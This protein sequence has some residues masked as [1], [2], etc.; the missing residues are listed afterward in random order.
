M[1]KKGVRVEMS[2]RDVEPV[3]GFISE[4]RSICDGLEPGPV[5]ALINGAL[6]R[7]EFGFAPPPLVDG[8]ETKEARGWKIPKPSNSVRVEREEWP[9]VCIIIPVFNSP[10]LLKRCLSSLL[11]TDYPG[12]VYISCVDNASTDPET[13]HIL[14]Q[15]DYPPLRFESPVGFASAVNAGIKACGGFS[16]YVLFN[17]DCQVIEEDWLTALIDWMEQR[18]QC[19][20]AGAKLLYPDGTLQH[21][22]MEIPKGS[23]G[24]HRY[25][26][27]SADLEEANYFEK[28]QSVTGAVYCIRGSVFDEIGYLDEGYKLGCEDSEFCLRAASKAG[29]EVWY[30]PTSVVQ[31]FDNGVRKTN[32]EDA[33]RIRTWAT[34]SDKKFRSEWG[35]FIDLAASGR[36]AFVL[37]DFNPVAGGCRVVGALA[38]YFINCGV[39]TTLYVTSH[40]AHG[41]DPDFPVLFDVKPLEDLEYA[42]IL[43]A[44]RF[45]TVA[46]TKQ[47]A[48]AR[49]FYLVQ[50][51]ETAMAKYC[52]GMEADVLTSY[53]QTEY[54]ILTIGEHLAA[55]LAEMGRTSTVLDVGLYRDLYPFIPRGISTDRPI[56]VLMYGCSV[57]YKGGDD[58]PKIAEAIRERL[59]NRVRINTYHRDFGQPVWADGHY[60]P[61]RTSEVAAVYADHDIYVYA[62][63]TDGFA[64]TPVEAMAC[65]TPV[66]MTDFPGKDQYARQGENCLIERFRDVEGVASAVFTLAR[67][68]ELRKR[69]SA[70]GA[71]TADRYDWSK[72]GRQYV[73]AMLGAPV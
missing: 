38:N 60:R 50:Q 32:S 35:P 37:P 62:S 28:V 10:D 1:T 42:D 29:K 40:R 34:E 48:A 69:L 33:S 55:Q 53:Q 68:P 23:C 21:A 15:Q 46:A 30:V 26:H 45:D 2:L 8:G 57:D 13:L 44:T 12:N 11:R 66:V 41:M 72:I 58:M 56:R 70:A 36:V 5:R 9:E 6:L 27:Q 49:R 71:E 52:G 20:I 61:K 16:F 19:A 47:I 3:K 7:L 24:K 39:E 64:M 4:I 18:P 17:Q 67:K 14:S 59:G 51:I 65:G 73:R 63:L 43:I 25:L 31:H 54:E 22:G